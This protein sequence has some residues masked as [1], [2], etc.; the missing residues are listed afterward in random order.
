MS[1]SGSSSAMIGAESLSGSSSAMISVDVELFAMFGPGEVIA[2]ALVDDNAFHSSV[3]AMI[4][5][6]DL[7]ISVFHTVL[8]S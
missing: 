6:C 7:I 5:S 4:T 2:V 1:L 8:L 3:K